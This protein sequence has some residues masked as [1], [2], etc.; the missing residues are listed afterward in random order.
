M[1]AGV[2]IES[3]GISTSWNASGVLDGRSIV[4][5]VVSLGFARL[6]VDYRVRE[7]AIQGILEAIG[8]GA[9]EV[10][11]IHNFSPLARDETPS[12]CGGDK[13]SL[14][15]LDETER[16]EAVELTRRSLQLAKQLGAR[17]LVLHTGEVEGIGADYF[18]QLAAIVK[19]RGVDCDEAKHLRSSLARERSRRRA[20]HLEAVKRSLEALLPDAIES[21]IRLCIENRYFYHQIPIYEDAIGL[22]RAIDS[23][24]VRYWHDIGHGHVLDALGFL[25]HHQW[26]LRLRPYVFGVHI[27]DAIF[28]HDH[29]APGKGE[30]DLKSILKIIPASPIKVLEVSNRVNAQEIR[31]ARLYLKE[32]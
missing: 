18:D 19:S 5:E 27:H 25:P 11:S 28:I 12:P 13:L 14:A 30:I 9:I 6:E 8:R 29:M 3:L 10:T 15:S 24:F 20:P 2:D 26:L 21:G 23:E 7:E 31:Q 17:A 22:L 4:D 1:I 32:L 16:R